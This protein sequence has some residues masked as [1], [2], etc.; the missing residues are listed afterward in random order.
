[1][2]P[3]LDI[4]KA[5]ATDASDFLRG[6][7]LLGWFVLVIITC[8]VLGVVAAKLPFRRIEVHHNPQVIN[9]VSLRNMQ[10]GHRRNADHS[11]RGTELRAMKPGWRSEQDP[12]ADDP[13]LVVTGAAGLMR[14]EPIPI[15]DRG[16]VRASMA[17]RSTYP[18]GRSPS[19]SDFAEPTTPKSF[20]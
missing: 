19:L 10:P 16:F 7:L 12:G 3:L 8:A 2:A 18:V 15:H 5:H 14:P 1:M 4:A 6:Q 13:P 11:V 9:S 17:P 20:V